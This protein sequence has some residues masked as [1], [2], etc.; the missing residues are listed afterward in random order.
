M[1]LHVHE[2]LGLL[3]HTVLSPEVPERSLWGGSDYGHGGLRLTGA[4]DAETT[5]ADGAR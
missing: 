5:E 3:S 1:P 4:G 2:N